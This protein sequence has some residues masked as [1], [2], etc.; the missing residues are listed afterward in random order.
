MERDERR[1]AAKNCLDQKGACGFHGSSK[2]SK[3]RHSHMKKI[4]AKPTHGRSETY[5]KKPAKRL[6]GIRRKSVH[7][8]KLAGILKEMTLEKGTDALAG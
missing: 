8:R 2:R 6:T 1:E 7:T 5:S 3:E 4:P